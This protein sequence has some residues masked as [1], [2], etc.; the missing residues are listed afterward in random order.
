M[1]FQQLKSVRQ[2][3][4]RDFNL[5]EVVLSLATPQPGVFRQIRELED[6][7]GIVASSAIVP[8]R[9]GPLAVVEALHLLTRNAT[10]VALRKDAYLRA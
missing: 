9:S 4:R 10:K 6:A 3:A 1:N 7:L 2:A 8:A 5:S